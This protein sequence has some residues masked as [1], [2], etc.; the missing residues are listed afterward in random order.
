MIPVAEEYKMRMACHPHDPGV[1]PQGY[2]GIYRVLGDVDG[3]KKFEQIQESPYHGFNLC[4]GTTAEMLQDPGR[5]LYAIIRYFGERKKIFNIHYR[6]IVGKRGDFREVYP[7]N[8]DVDMYRAMQTLKEVEYPY[9]VMPDHM[10]MHPD[11]P[12]RRQAYAFGFGYIKAM[13][14]AVDRAG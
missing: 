7:D 5:E 1:P 10:P 13:I 12:N 11:D 4:L 8:G 2:Q 3:L 14:Q 9:L 6:N